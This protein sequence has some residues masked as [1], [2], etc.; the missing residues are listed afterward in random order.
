MSTKEVRIRPAGW[1]SAP[2]EEQFALSDMDHTMPKIYVQIVEVF[3]LAPLFDKTKVV[4]SMAKSLEFTLSQFPILAGGLKMDAENGRLWV[5]K[6]KDSEVSLFV[7]DLE[8]TFPSFGELDRTDFPAATFKGHMLLPKAVTEKQL[9]L[10]LGE[11]QEDYLI[12]STFQI[13]FIKG[14]LVLGVA[15]HHDCS[16]GPGCDGFLTTWAQNSAAVVNGTSPKAVPEGT[17]NRSRLSAKKPDAG[18]WKE[19]DQKFLVLKDGGGPAPPPPGDF[20]MPELAIRMWHFPKSKTEELKSRAMTQTGES[21]ISTYDAIMSILWK[22]ITRSKLELLHPDFGKGV[23]LVHAVDTR[24]VSDPPLPE[25]MMGNAVALPRT[26]PIKISELLGEDNLSEIAQRVR[27]SI[28]TITSQYVA[29]LPEWIAGLNDRRWINI[30][31][32]SFLGMDLTGT[33]WQDMNV[34]RKHD[35]GFGIARA[36]RFPDPQF[37]GYVFVYPSRADVKENAIDEGV[38]VCVCLEKGCH[39]RLMKDQELLR[40]PQPRGN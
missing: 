18:R 20:K 30:N 6:R 8:E 34:Y 40:Y 10:P 37:E 28:K 36:I 27:K 14:G 21:W 15:I 4:D 25:T 19:L 33:S 35:F 13:N 31:M 23:I 32:S 2:A 22:S 29:E 1:E 5:T 39:D 7:Q 24:K 38:E 16:D 12:I 9:F 3:K 17:M 26:E 11:N